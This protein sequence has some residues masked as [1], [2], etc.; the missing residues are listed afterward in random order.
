MTPEQED[1]ALQSCHPLY[2]EWCKEEDGHEECEEENE[3][4]IECDNCGEEW[5]E[6]QLA[7]NRWRCPKC[8]FKIGD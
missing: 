5:D 7:C 3:I 8:K 4:L 2:R 1:F 6:S